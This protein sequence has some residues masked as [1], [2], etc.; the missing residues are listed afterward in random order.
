M[1]ESTVPLK[2]HLDRRAADLID[3]G[4]DDDD[5]LD[6]P[7][8]SVW[9][10]VSSQWL[11]IGRSKGYGPP[12]VRLSPSRVR[13]R[14]GDVRR[15]LRERTIDHQRPRGGV[16]PCRAEDPGRR[17]GRTRAPPNLPKATGTLPIP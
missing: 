14:R 11:E 4:G 8:T 2:H 10:G 6:T 12:Y 9:L 15:W 13:Y 7:T 17:A 1:A 3:E 16:E 5:L